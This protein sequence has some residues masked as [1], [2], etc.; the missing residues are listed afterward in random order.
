MF[1]EI[2]VK[3]CT[4]GSIVKYFFLINI[5]SFTKFMVFD[6]LLYLGTVRTPVTVK[7]NIFLSKT[8]GHHCYKRKQ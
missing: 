4:I 7:Q 2:S 3:L 8:H 1:R 5:K 6:I